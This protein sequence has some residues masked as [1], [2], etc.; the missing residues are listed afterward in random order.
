M[1]VSQQAFF[2]SDLFPVFVCQPLLIEDVS[3]TFK[4]GLKHKETF[5]PYNKSHICTM[6][7][8]N[9]HIPGLFKYSKYFN[10]KSPKRTKLY[11]NLTDLYKVCKEF[12]RYLYL[13]RYRYQVPIP[14]ISIGM[15]KIGKNPVSVWY[16]EYLG[17][18]I[19]WGISVSV[20]RYHTD[21]LM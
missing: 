19:G 20:T 16:G 1:F 8:G 12:D 13:Y 6:I 17:Y 5:F 9:S 15:K 18:C 21:F 4:W 14:G 11:L 3:L 2:T 7:P 10:I